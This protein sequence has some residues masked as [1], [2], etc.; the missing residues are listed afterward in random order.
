[1]GSNRAYLEQMARQLQMLG[2][3]DDYVVQL[4]RRVQALGAG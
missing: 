2:I 3:H 1:M 4:L